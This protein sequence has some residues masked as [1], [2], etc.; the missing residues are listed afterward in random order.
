MAK[1]AADSSRHLPM[2]HELS[3]HR[4]HSD[5]F[6]S[7]LEKALLVRSVSD[8]TDPSSILLMDACDVIGGSQGLHDV[9]S[10]FAF[11]NS[12]LRACRWAGTI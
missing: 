12:S 4:F 6:A 7:G 2:D 9:L 5:M 1:L 11:G 3:A 10:N 8:F